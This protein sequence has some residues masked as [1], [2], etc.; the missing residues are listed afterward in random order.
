MD[1]FF[2][3]HQIKSLI[4]GLRNNI[5]HEYG[6]SGKYKLEFYACKFAEER[7]I[8]TRYNMTNSLNTLIK[9]LGCYADSALQEF[10][11]EFWE[12]VKMEEF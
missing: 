12:I 11:I 4:N 1:K 2:S 6:Q 5:F 9:I 3:S 10:N 8:N 7:G